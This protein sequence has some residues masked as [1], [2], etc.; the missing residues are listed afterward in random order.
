MYGSLLAFSDD[1]FKSM[2]FGTVAD[3]KD[4]KEGI[5]IVTLIGDFL[6]GIYQRTFIMIE[7]DV[8]FEPYYHVMKKIQKMSNMNFPLEKYIIYGNTQVDPPK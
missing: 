7:S 3:R 6:E 5:I 8:Y 2:F 1:E 4:L